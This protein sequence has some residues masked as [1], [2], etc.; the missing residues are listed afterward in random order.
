M[1]G[2]LALGAAQ[3]FAEVPAWSFF[4]GTTWAPFAEEPRFGVL[5]LVVATAQIALG[6]ILVAAP[7]GLLSAVYLHHYAGRRTGAVAAAAIAALASVPTVVFGYAA[8]NAAAPLVRWAWPGAEAFNGASAMLVVGLMTAPTVAFLGR[9]ALAAVPPA[10]FRAGM[11]L[12]ASRGRVAT[13]V[14]APAAARGIAAAVLLATAR[15]VGETMIVTMAAGSHAGLAWSPLQGV[16]TLTAFVAQANL[17][18]VAPAGLESRAVLVVAALLF[19]V[20]YATHAAGRALLSRR[21]AG[22]ARP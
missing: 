22:A 21:P 15:A 19:A 2:V 16:R 7:L 12:G 10:Y 13:L 11:A 5:P 1:L 18:D 4:A 3:F 6:A 8:L 20:S 14:V 17:G 9:E